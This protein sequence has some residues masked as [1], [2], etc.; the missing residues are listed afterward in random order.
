MRFDNLRM[1]HLGRPF[2]LVAAAFSVLMLAVLDHV[3]L[4]GGPSLCGILSLVVGW[5]TLGSDCIISRLL[6]FLLIPIECCV[7]FTLGTG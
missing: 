7:W 6:D 1:M 4:A 2:A 3:L 5:L